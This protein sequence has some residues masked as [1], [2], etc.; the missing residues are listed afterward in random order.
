MGQSAMADVDVIDWPESTA[1][2]TCGLSRSWLASWAPAP[3]LIEARAQLQATE[4]R[5]IRLA[6]ACLLLGEAVE[7]LDAGQQLRHGSTT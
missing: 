7:R 3:V 1:V 6:R 4:A 2:V 5:A